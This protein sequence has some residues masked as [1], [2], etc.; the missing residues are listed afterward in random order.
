MANRRGFYVEVAIPVMVDLKSEIQS[1]GLCRRVHWRQLFWER[2][3][4]LH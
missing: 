2:V 3:P 4:I 1:L